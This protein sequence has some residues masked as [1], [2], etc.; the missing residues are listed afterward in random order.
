MRTVNSVRQM[1]LRRTAKQVLVFQWLS[2]SCASAAR[3][4]CGRTGDAAGCL[5]QLACQVEG[6]ERALARYLRCE[7]PSEVRL[8]IA[9]CSPHGQPGGENSPCLVLCN[10]SG[11]LIYKAG[12][13]AAQI[14]GEIAV[15]LM[16]LYGRHQQADVLSDDLGAA[17]A[18]QLF[19]A[20][21]EAHDSCLVVYH[22]AAMNLGG[23]FSCAAIH[24]ALARFTYGDRCLSNCS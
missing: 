9:L 3:I 18:E 11:F 8:S 5:V 16:R 20:G 4:Y 7:M 1:M 19:A 14:A 21:I 17:E 22:Q 13:H 6:K 24:R 12:R 23:R 2:I 10:H 15:M